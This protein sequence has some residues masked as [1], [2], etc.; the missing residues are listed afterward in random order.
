M[1]NIEHTLLLIFERL[2]IIDRRMDGIES[3]VRRAENAADTANNAAQTSQLALDT[4]SSRLE[5]LRKEHVKNH[6]NNNSLVPQ[7]LI[8]K[9]QRRSKKK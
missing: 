4:V 8:S 5:I 7:M 1:N 9:R 3:Y 6:P 2:D